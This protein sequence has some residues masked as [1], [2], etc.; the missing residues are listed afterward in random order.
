MVIS[1]K[2][3]KELSEQ[4][5]AYSDAAVTWPDERVIWINKVGAMDT[6]MRLLGFAWADIIKEYTKF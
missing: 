4:R 5:Q 6:T 3:L 1:K 2:A